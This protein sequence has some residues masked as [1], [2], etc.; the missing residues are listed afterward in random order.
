[1][2]RSQIL[3]DVRRTLS[4]TPDAYRFGVEY[5]PALDRA[6]LPNPTGY[7]LDAYHRPKPPQ[8]QPQPP[9]PAPAL[10]DI[11]IDRIRAATALL[12]SHDA[13]L[14]AA[15]SQALDARGAAATPWEPL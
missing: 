11:Y 6:T 1:M 8:P 14:A 4:T 12:S 7:G 2:T 3:K 5:E 13:A 10:A 15:I 9:S